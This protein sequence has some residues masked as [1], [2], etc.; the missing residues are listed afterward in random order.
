MSSGLELP[1]TTDMTWEELIAKAE[2][3]ARD[4]GIPAE[5]LQRPQVRE[6]ALVTF[7]NK[8]SRATGPA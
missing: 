7:L 8:S 3:H 5:Q 6:T 2:E 1:S 4:A